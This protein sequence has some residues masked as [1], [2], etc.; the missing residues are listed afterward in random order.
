MLLMPHYYFDITNGHHL[1]DPAG[2]DCKDDADAI[3]IAKRQAL[4]S[5]REPGKP[6]TSCSG[7]GQPKAGSL[8]S[9][10]R[11]RDAAE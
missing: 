7:H 9:A 10:V 5:A 3:S 6:A 11:R 2:L 4:Q 1:I 8:K